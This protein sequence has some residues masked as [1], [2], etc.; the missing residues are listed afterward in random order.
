MD[1]LSIQNFVVIDLY[2]GSYTKNYKGHEIFNLDRNPVTGKFYGYCPPK[3][4]LNINKLG[5]NST[6]SFIDGILVI[7]VCKKENSNDREII[8]FSLNSRVYKTGQPGKGLKRIFEDKD[9]KKGVCSYSVMSDNLYDLRNRLYKFEIKINDYSNKMFHAQ[10]FYCGTYPALDTAILAYIK[11]IVATE[12]ILD[13]DDSYEQDEIQRANPADSD[14]LNNAANNPLNIANDTQGNNIIKN[15]RV[16]KKAL[17]DAHYTCAIDINHKTFITTRK[18]PYMEGHHLI[19][20]TVQ[21]SID[22]KEK[23][24]KNIDCYENIVCL[25]PNC[26]R[27]IHFGEWETKSKKIQLLFKKQQEKLNNIGISITE[28]ELLELYKL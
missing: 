19:P 2:S 26:H 4:G 12:E 7:Y 21:N 6:A 28:K 15:S 25:C 20:C 24:G 3:D 10:R 13:N 14:E 27:E 16:S 18:V 23:F 8:A 5:A 1:R 9:G 17:I 22:F 11:N